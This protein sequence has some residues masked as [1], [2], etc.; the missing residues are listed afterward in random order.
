M[1]RGVGHTPVL[2]T[3]LAY[4]LD[5]VLLEYDALDYYPWIIIRFPGRG[6]F[7]R[8][9]VR[10]LKRRK[11][12]GLWSRGVPNRLLHSKVEPGSEKMASES[13]EWTIQT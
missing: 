9:S 5:L 7:A 1:S 11:I 3:H 4:D 13:G 12:G 6:E 10:G 8:L 2:V